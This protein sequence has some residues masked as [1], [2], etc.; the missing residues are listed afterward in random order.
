MTVD[1][2]DQNEPEG[3][4]SDADDQRPQPLVEMTAA[5]ARLAKEA[6]RSSSFDGPA[7]AGSASAAPIDPSAAC[8]ADAV[9][10]AET[11][12][13]IEALLFASAEPRAAAELALSLPEAAPIGQ[14]LARLQRQYGGRGVELVEV[15]G[16][17]RFQTAADLRFLFERAA[18]P[19]RLGRAA[20][21]TLA[22]IAYHQPVTRSEIEEIRGV[23]LASGALDT[24]LEAGLVRPRGRRKSVG[25]PLTFGTT[26]FFLEYF[27][28]AELD[29]LPGREDMRAAGLLDMRMPSD[30]AFPRPSE[31]LA[32][33]E[34][35]LAGSDEDPQFQLDFL[36][37]EA[38]IAE[39][40]Q[41]G[42]DLDPAAENEASDMARE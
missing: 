2:E 4:A 6:S 13:R 17:W 31:Q 33:D 11:M 28:L 16:K 15:A 22:V 19:T 30:L 10:L 41:S 21:E 26:G 37:D 27:G 20:L 34:E 18:R 29:H 38:A 14:A 42:A 36:A 25:R 35:P 12:R 5:I 24:L 3:H 1:L 8:A 40:T 32:P 9:K 7:R 39:P 23:G